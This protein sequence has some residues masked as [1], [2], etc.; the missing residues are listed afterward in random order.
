ML[1]SLLF[2]HFRTFNKDYAKERY[3]L[4][5]FSSKEA[6]RSLSFSSMSAALSPEGWTTTFRSGAR[7]L[8]KSYSAQDDARETVK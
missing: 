5:D 2:L 6:R 3:R 4:Q 8:A 7:P 1:V